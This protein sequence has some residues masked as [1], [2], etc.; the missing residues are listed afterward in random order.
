D[1]N[2]PAPAEVPVWDDMTW[3]RVTRTL[4]S[5]RNQGTLLGALAT[6]IDENGQLQQPEFADP[7]GF[8]DL[9]DPNDPERPNPLAPRSPQ[10]LTLL[11][12]GSRLIAPDGLEISTH[13]FEIVGMAQPG[14]GELFAAGAGV[15]A[16]GDAV[17]TLGCALQSTDLGFT[18][19]ALVSTGP[20]RTA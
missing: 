20:I 8:I 9:F 12:D 17:G 4:Y 10:L 14:K 18:Q 5:V 16:L 15:V 19:G 6:P 3:D 7:N 1:P 11:S 2:V 13:P